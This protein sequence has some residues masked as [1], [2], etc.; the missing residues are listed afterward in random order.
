MARKADLA[1]ALVPAQAWLHG[2]TSPTTPEGV[3]AAAYQ[4]KLS[5]LESEAKTQRRG[6][7]GEVK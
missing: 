5:A 2:M 3:R 4:I 7:W 6:G 1:E